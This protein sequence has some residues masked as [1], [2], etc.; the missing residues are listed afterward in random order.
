MRITQQ[1]QTFMLIS[2]AKCRLLKI[3]LSRNIGSNKPAS[4]KITALPVNKTIAVEQRPDRHEFKTAKATK[5][6]ANQVSTNQS[7]E[8]IK[9]EKYHIDHAYKN[10]NG[11]CKT[12]N[13]KNILLTKK[14]ILQIPQKCLSTEID[15]TDKSVNR[16]S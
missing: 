5:H 6:S 8:I 13:Y 1:R 16:L 10:I 2:R 15:I 11:R 7:T 3:A 9:H 4:L 12:S 14:I